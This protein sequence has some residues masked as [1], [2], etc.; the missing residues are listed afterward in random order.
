[1]TVVDHPA[2]GPLGPDE[3]AELE[4][5][6]AELAELRAATPTVES[7]APP[8]PGRDRHGWRWVAVA[9]LLV[10]AGL[11]RWAR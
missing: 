6:R 3:R 4:R 1:M 10:L 8:K 11:P 7:K 2:T 5:L 9:L